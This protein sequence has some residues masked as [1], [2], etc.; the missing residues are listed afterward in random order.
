MSL[1]GPVQEA[2]AQH[3]RSPAMMPLNST[4]AVVLSGANSQSYGELAPVLGTKLG[5]FGISMDRPADL[6][7]N[8][9]QATGRSA[10]RSRQVR[11]AAPGW[12]KCP[13]A[14]RPARIAALL[15]KLCWFGQRKHMFLFR[16]PVKKE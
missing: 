9:E 8:G 4:A 2:M 10:A 6:S 16:G 12:W 15:G 1:L 11:G 3:G 5:S 7:C 14:A 13:K